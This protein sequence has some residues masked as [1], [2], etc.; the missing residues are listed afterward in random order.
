MITPE[1]LEYVR[2]EFAEGRTREEIH[3]ILV[4]D[5]GWSE[6]DINEAFK[7]A[8]PMP[9]IVLADPVISE[10]KVEEKIV[11]PVASSVLKSEVQENTSKAWQFQAVGR[12]NLI[13]ILFGLFCIVSWYFYQPQITSFWNSGVEKSQRL[14]MDSWNSLADF[15]TNSW[16]SLKEFSVSSWDSYA[17]IFKQ[18]SFPALKMPSIKLPYLGT[19]DNSATQEGVGANIVK[20]C[21]TGL[22]PQVKNLASENNP[23]LT[24]LGASALKCE[25]AKG[26]LKDDFFP[27]I[28]EI[29]KSG[30][31][32]NFKLSYGADSSLIDI[33]GKKLS[34]QYI[35]CPINIVK[36]IDDTKPANPQFIAPEKTDLSKYAAQIYFYGTLVLFVESNLDQNRIQELG[37]RGDYVQS[38]IASYN[39]SQKN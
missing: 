2:E 9:D 4:A 39:L 1:L 11:E 28:F 5:G 36:A 13:F 23:V 21:G 18:I 32:C 6:P 19:A 24:C 37:C 7:V 29:T 33:T 12:P 8:L 16:V 17:N 34:G 22:S 3:K 14:S 38:V 30:D 10:K 31:S 25:N 26:I 27:T 20:D 35:S 15:S